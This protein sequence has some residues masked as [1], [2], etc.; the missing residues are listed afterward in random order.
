M[1]KA[2]FSVVHHP[3]LQLSKIAMVYDVESRFALCILSPRVAVT[4]SRYLGFAR[5]F[6]A[7]GPATGWIGGYAYGREK[8][9]SRSSTGQITIGPQFFSPGNARNLFRAFM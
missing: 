4:H 5:V 3:P 8:A 1:C 2:R 7:V 6:E 9:P